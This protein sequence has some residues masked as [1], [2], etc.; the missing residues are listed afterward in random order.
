MCKYLDNDVVLGNLFIKVIE[1]ELDKITFNKIYDF[2]YYA[3]LKLNVEEE[4]YILVSREL[5]I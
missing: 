3:S 1:R 2:I 5:T 4:T